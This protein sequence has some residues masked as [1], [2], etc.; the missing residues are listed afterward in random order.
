MGGGKNLQRIANERLLTTLKKFPSL[1]DKKTGGE[2]GG[3]R[4]ITRPSFGNREKIKAVGEKERI[5]KVL[6]RVAGAMI[7]RVTA[8]FG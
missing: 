2:M 6:N 5:D 4:I 7:K 8:G 1:V 3:K